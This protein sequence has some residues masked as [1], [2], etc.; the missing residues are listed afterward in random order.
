MSTLV[1]LTDAD[2]WALLGAHEVG[3][4]AFTELAMPTIVPV[5]Y[6]LLGDRLVLQ[7]RTEQL[8]ARLDGQVV[9]LEVD[10]VDRTLRGSSVV[11]TGTAERLLVPG[12]SRTAGRDERTAIRLTVGKVRGLHLHEAA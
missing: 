7:C 3:H 2:C 11:V 6:T 5:R 1:P 10:D 4:V 12:D 8:A 9:A